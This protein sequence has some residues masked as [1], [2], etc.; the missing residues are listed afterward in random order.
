MGNSRLFG[1]AQ[2]LLAS[3]I[4]IGMQAFQRSD[5]SLRSQYFNQ[6]LRSTLS[7]APHYTSRV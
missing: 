5:A 6:V 7:R 4:G 3:H 2:Y 1:I